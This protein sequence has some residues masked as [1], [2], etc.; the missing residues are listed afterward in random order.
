M[1]RYVQIHKLTL[2]IAEDLEREA[3][4]NGGYAEDEVFERQRHR[5]VLGGRVQESGQVGHRRTEQAI[6]A[7]LWR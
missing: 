2:T 6:L 3:D 4:Q 7:S 5:D 1:F